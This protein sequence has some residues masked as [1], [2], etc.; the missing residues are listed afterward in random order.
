MQPSRKQPVPRHDK[1]STM[2][3]TGALLA[4]LVGG[5]CAA[6][7]EPLAPKTDPL[8][9][10]LVG[11]LFERINR[12]EK[13]EFEVL[14]QALVGAHMTLRAQAAT[15]LGDSGDKRAIPFL[16]DALSDESVHVGANYLDPGDATTRH[17]AN[18][19]LIKLT[20][21][22]FGFVWS[23]P[24]EKRQAAIQKW[25]QWYRKSVEA[26]VAPDR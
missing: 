16:I 8:K 22:D 7:A 19:A 1:R 9:Q 20:K 4:I 17:R 12:Q 26:A 25:T 10:E 18:Q 15:L 23:D 3:T 11:P 21:Q 14:C 2:K 13:I 6:H 5:A 24:K